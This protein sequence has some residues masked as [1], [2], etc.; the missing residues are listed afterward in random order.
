M[1]APD[2]PA[3]LELHEAAIARDCV[4]LDEP[5]DAAAH[6]HAALVALTRASELRLG[7]PGNLYLD[8]ADTALR[9]AGRDDLAERVWERGPDAVLDELWRLT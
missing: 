5:A 4:P 7:W 6:L 8:T 3:L 9:A 2:F 1:D